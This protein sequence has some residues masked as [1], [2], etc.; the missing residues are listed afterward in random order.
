VEA[1]DD[2]AAEVV[3]D[4]GTL[5]VSGAY[6]AAAA[7][8]SAGCGKLRWC[9]VLK[10]AH[11]CLYTDKRQGGEAGGSAAGAAGG[12]VVEWRMTVLQRWCMT[13]ERCR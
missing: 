6:A 12:H 2:S 8:A 10:T 5:Q 9:P 13:R 7:A 1:E 3:H 4:E 11:A